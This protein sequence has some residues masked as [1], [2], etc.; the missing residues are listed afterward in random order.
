MAVTYVTASNG[1]KVDNIFL[2]PVFDAD[3]R[4]DLRFAHSAGIRSQLSETRLPIGRLAGPYPVYTQ[5]ES[6]YVYSNLL[7]YHPL[8]DSVFYASRARNVCIGTYHA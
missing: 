7:K 4:G 6:Y 2:R 1:Q 5:R 3:S 8:R